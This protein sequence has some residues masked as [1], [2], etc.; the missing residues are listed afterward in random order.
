MAK[1]LI[2][3]AYLV[4]FM[5]ANEASIKPPKGGVCSASRLVNTYKCGQ[6]GAQR[7][8]RRSESLPIYLPYA[9]SPSSYS[10][11]VIESLSHVWL[12]CD[13]MNCSSPGSFVRGIFQTRIL[14]W[15]AT[16]FSRESSWPRDQTWVSCIGRWVLYHLSHQ[17]SPKQ[18]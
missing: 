7:G 16:P 3:L 11:V 6:S 9:S 1:D 4:D 8:H 17:G 14:T 15:I 13:S 5:E 2:N 10:W 12:F 18:V